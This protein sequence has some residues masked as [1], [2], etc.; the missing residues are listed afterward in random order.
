MVPQ[1]PAALKEYTFPVPGEHMSLS[2]NSTTT[3][4]KVNGDTDTMW[5][6]VS[7]ISNM[8]TSTTVSKKSTTSDVSKL[9]PSPPTHEPGQDDVKHP[10]KKDKNKNKYKKFFKEKLK[11]GK[12]S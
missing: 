4:T 11:I 1:L 5:S 10:V 12:S 3:T 2:S 7:D 8:T 6:S 9:L